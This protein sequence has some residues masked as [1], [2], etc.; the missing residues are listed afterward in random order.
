MLIQARIPD[1][2]A[3]C[4]AVL[5]GFVLCCMLL[6][7]AGACP[8]FP[9]DANVKYKPE[10]PGRE[11]WDLPPTVMA[12]GWGDCEDLA[13]WHAA[14]LRVTG[15]DPVA[16]VAV[17]RTGH[18]KLHAVVRRADGSYDDPSYDL[19]DRECAECRP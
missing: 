17:V 18:N 4:E 15:E 16:V 10:P 13:M 1:H 2:A 12:R 7:R 5:E 9:H 3:A 19:Y 8:P 6:I 11:D 14:G